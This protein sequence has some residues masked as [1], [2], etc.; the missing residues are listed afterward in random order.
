MKS[1]KNMNRKE[2]IEVTESFISPELTQNQN[3]ENLSALRD[4][5]SKIESK[6]TQKDKLIVQLLQLKYLMHDYLNNRNSND[7]YHFGFF[8]KEY[9]NRI[10]RKNKEFANEIG[11]E[12]SLLS[13]IINRHRKP[14]EEFIIRLELHSNKNFPAIIWY[15]LFEKEREKEIMNDIELRNQLKKDIKHKLEISF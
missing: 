11:I 14:S 5:R 12:P 10:E 7:I 13:Q 2:A 3:E 6:R 9:I 8:V 15:R 1:R 4:Y